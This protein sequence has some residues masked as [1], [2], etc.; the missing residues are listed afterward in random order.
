VP[1]WNF[2]K[3]V[4]VPAGKSVSTFYEFVTNEEKEY[5]PMI[6][7][8]SSSSD[9]MKAEQKVKL[10]VKSDLMGDIKATKNGV[11]IFPMVLETLYSLL[12]II[13][14]FI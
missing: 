11:L 7:V 4:F 2:K 5:E 3:Q 9:V 12:G 10:T 6:T 1:T 8:V 13:G 14:S